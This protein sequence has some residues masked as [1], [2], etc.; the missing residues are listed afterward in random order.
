MGSLFLLEYAIRLKEPGHRKAHDRR[1]ALL[2]RQPEDH[3]RTRGGWQ[4]TCCDENEEN[5]LRA[6][7][8]R[9]LGH[10][11]SLGQSCSRGTSIAR[12]GEEYGVRT[13]HWA[14]RHAEL[15]WWAPSRLSSRERLALQGWRQ[16]PVA[17]QSA[18]TNSPLGCSARAE[19]AWWGSLQPWSRGMVAAAMFVVAG[20]GGGSAWVHFGPR[21]AGSILRIRRGRLGV[22]GAGGRHGGHGLL[23]QQPRPGCRVRRRLCHAHCAL[24]AATATVD[25]RRRFGREARTV[26]HHGRRAPT[27][28]RA[29]LDN[30]QFVVEVADDV[31]R[32]RWCSAGASIHNE[33]G[34]G[35]LC[36][37]RRTSASSRWPTAPTNT[38]TDGAG[39]RAGRR[40]RRALR[41]AV[42]P[43]RPHASTVRAPWRWTQ[44]LPVM[45]SA[46]RTT[47]SSRA[48]PM[49]VTAVE[50][51]LRGQRLREDQTAA[52]FDVDRRR[53]RHQVEQGRRRRHKGFVSAST[54]GT[55]DYRGGR[56]RHSGGRRYLRIAGGD[57]DGRR[58]RTT[59]CI[60]TSRRIIAGG[61]AGQSTAGDDAVHAETRAH[62]SDGG[63]VNAA[64]CYEGLRSGEG[65]TS[66]VARRISWPATTA[67]TRP[68]RTRPR[69]MMRQTHPRPAQRPRQ[70]TCPRATRR[71]VPA[72]R[73][74]SRLQ[75]TCRKAKP[76]ATCRKAA[77]CV[78]VPWPKAPTR[79][80]GTAACPTTGMAE[81]G[82]GVSNSRTVS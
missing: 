60:P 44:L 66:T 73:R 78:A 57:L 69:T 26:D 16:P 46:R 62:R 63:T 12:S 22:N 49:C 13:V 74:A 5:R 38:L 71:R 50:D 79:A 55:F 17:Q 40:L 4:R 72:F 2:E 24:P 18:R 34:A 35:D 9:E 48:A 65:R 8:G 39:L 37:G 75:A 51:A 11:Q 19:L 54:G 27:W 3:V 31:T 41:H 14:V 59:R 67:S 10:A 42:Q 21:R 15:A 32:F 1:V 29:Q 64:A 6:F 77:A 80:C 61:S 47:S 28:C 20:W 70:A 53:R 58:L 68:R 7:V 45:R 56:R 23:V 81:G 76:P 25:G 36:E 30:G 82:R 52:T 43:G 33:D